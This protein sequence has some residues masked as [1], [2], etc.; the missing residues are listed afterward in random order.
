MAL[1]AVVTITSS[2]CREQATAIVVEF[3]IGGESAQSAQSLDVLLSCDDDDS[4]SQRVSF[5]LMLLG[6][7][8]KPSLAI[9]TAQG[10]PCEMI[11]AA[12][13]FSESSF[14]IAVCLDQ[15][16]SIQFIRTR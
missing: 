10:T 2:S 11:L 15:T 3:Q 9:E 4:V 5:D 12:Q 13:V 16:I 7:G 1:A 8:V 6:E 14:P